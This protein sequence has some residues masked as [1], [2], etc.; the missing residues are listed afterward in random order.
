M[1]NFRIKRWVGIFLLGMPFGVGAEGPVTLRDAAQEV[2]QHNPELAA[3]REALSAAEAREKASR[4]N[5]YPQISASADYKRGGAGTVFTSPAADVAGAGVRA[6]QNLFEGLKTLAAVDIQRARVEAAR[7]NRD[8][9]EARLG[10]ELKSAFGDLLFAQE[11][12]VLAQRILKRRQDNLDLVELRFEG[13]RE[14]KGSYLR[15][16][17]ARRQAQFESAQAE[18][19]VSV[20]GTRLARVLGRDLYNVPVATGSFLTQTPPPT[21]DF[22]ALAHVT[23]NVRLAEADLRGAEAG[24]TLSRGDYYPSLDAT[25]SQTWLDTRWPPED[26]AWSGGISLSLPL[27]AGGAHVQGVRASQADLARV[28]ALATNVFTQAFLDLKTDWTVFRDAREN[29]DVQREFTEASEVRALISRSQYT[30][31]LLSFDDWDLIENDL[32][33]THKQWLAVQRNAVRA[34]AAWENTQGKGLNP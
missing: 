16:K 22:G 29:V 6:S 19:D 5:F 28:R 3:A 33:N 13:G 32:I 21:P 9:V 30:N 12:L 34:E 10:L 27:F 4:S 25:L 1:K 18:R 26:R 23:P 31:G 14:H 2:L 7:A 17:A 8:R 20:A 11:N 24:L 15:I